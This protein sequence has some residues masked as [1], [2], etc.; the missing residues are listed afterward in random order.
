MLSLA[1]TLC[2]CNSN[3]Q[4]A[5]T[6]S[7]ADSEQNAVS[8]SPLFGP[9]PVA[10]TVDVMNSRAISILIQQ[11]MLTLSGNAITILQSE[12]DNSLEEA[13]V[14]S[15]KNVSEKTVSK[16]GTAQKGTAQKGTAQKGTAPKGTASE[17]TAQNKQDTKGK[18]GLNTGASV[19][20]SILKADAFD[21]SV[22]VINPTVNNTEISPEV[23]SDVP[24][25]KDDDPPATQQA[26]EHYDY[27]PAP[28]SEL[29]PEKLDTDP[30]YYVEKP[31]DTEPKPTPD[32]VINFE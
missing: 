20:E 27:Y 7:N 30:V 26:E 28:P 21:T 9:N 17:L 29:E 3:G 1:L 2:A 4:Q 22:D 25:S 5:V 18:D 13:S 23:K 10:K 16:K 24:Y 32:I 12:G 15:K 19:S 14:S 6:L 8:K 11:D 31:D